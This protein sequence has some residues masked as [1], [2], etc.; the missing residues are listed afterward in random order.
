MDI[1][2][3]PLPVPIAPL[4]PYEV[5]DTDQNGIYEFDLTTLSAGI[6]G[7]NPSG[8]VISYHET[9]TD[10][11][12]GTNP[13][14]LT[15]PYFN[16]IPY[17]QTLWVNVTNPLTGCYGII[18]IQIK[19]NESPRMPDLNDLVYCD[20]DSNN[21]NGITSIN[22]AQQ[23]PLI[24]AAQTIL[25]ISNYTVTYYTS[26]LDA[27]QQVNN[28]INTTTF[29]G[30]N[31][32]IWVV[33]EHNITG[34]T[35]I[36]EFD[37]IVNIPLALTPPPALS[38]CDD[39]SQPNNTYTTFDLTIREAVITQGLPG[40]TVTYYP[41][42]ANALAHTNAIL[43]PT[44]YINTQAAVQTLGIMVTS[45]AGCR[46][47]TTM[48]IR[49]LPVPTPNRT[50]IPILTP[51][52]E[53][54][55]GSGQQFFNLTVNQTYILNNDPNVTAHYFHTLA[56]ATAVPPVN[57]ILNPAN[58][59]IG[60]SSIAGQVP[61]PVNYVQ[62]IYIAVT[63]NLFTEYTGQNCYVIVEQPFIINP[64]PI[65]K[66]I[67]EQQ[68]CEEDPLG[69]DGIEVFDLTSYNSD[70][71]SLNNT[72]PASS[73]TVN[74]Y[75]D[76]GYTNLITNPTSYSNVTNPQ[77]IYVS[78][79]AT[80]TYVDPVTGISHTTS[81]TSRD[82][83]DIRVNP[84]PTITQPA[85]PL[86]TCDVNDSQNDGYD[87]NYDLSSLV[88][89]ILN[90]QDPTQFTVTFYDSEYNPDATPPLVPTP[91]NVASYDVYTHTYWAAVTNNATGCFKTTSF[92][93]VVEETPE[94]FIKNDPQLNV[95]CVDYNTHQV[96]RPLLLETENLAIPYLVNQP[97][98]TY[99]WFEDGVAIA[100]SNSSTLLIDF[101]LNDT[102]SS[103]FTV[104]I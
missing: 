73:Y 76:L 74:F 44:A 103:I 64:L 32:T 29:T 104:V 25:P 39:D 21:Q 84:K 43:N 59:Y 40:Y 95:I 33:V 67:G 66:V 89:E 16:I 52:C 27:Q 90:G 11:Q 99:E 75:T 4:T 8:N 37:I 19:V 62:N 69:N 100:N 17:L 23:T 83:F 63:S 34:C 87:E 68:I 28:I 91:L 61:R 93:I 12:M 94:P 7:A 22:L 24:L 102:T 55:V 80:D 48:D 14:S 45:P 98:Y 47:Y 50:N 96:V 92:N 46:S 10:A 18:P 49:V 77:T 71:L 58:A 1:R 79:T 60:D 9:Q 57:E 54:A 35:K 88:T 20:E 36:G 86:A 51:Q 53:D 13:I 2:V 97:N 41:S 72:T 5:C 85:N 70:L 42:Y 30:T 31:Q 3:E 38:V 78:I 56:D 101:A 82:K 26:L 15:Q 6:L 81:C 65:V